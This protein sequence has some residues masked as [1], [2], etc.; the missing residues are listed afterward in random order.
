MAAMMS[1]LDLAGAAQTFSIMGPQ[2]AAAVTITQLG[3]TNGAAAFRSLGPDFSGELL[4]Q[5]GADF[6]AQMMEA[7]GI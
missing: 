2:Q 7:P 1:A 4:L 5:L 6:T 3:P